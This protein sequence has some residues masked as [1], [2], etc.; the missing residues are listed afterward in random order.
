ML[1][2]QQSKASNKYYHYHSVIEQTV[3]LQE[4]TNQFLCIY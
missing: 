1:H 2:A 3:L 4:F